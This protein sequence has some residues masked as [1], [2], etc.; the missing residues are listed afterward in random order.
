MSRT[1]LINLPR[2]KNIWYN[3]EIRLKTYLILFA[4][5]SR[6]N[7]KENKFKAI[8]KK[9]LKK[10]FPECILLDGDPNDIQGIPDLFIF[11][12]T[13]YAALECKIT[14]RAIKQPNQQ[15]YVDLINSMS[16]ARFIYP[17][18]KEEV[19]YDLQKAFGIR[20]PTRFS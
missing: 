4:L 18:N 10:I 20:R 13:N 3:R 5:E 15:Y 14:E 17:E 11:W 9:D 12:G 16:F 8:L 6:V 7:M 1:F 2:D 19:L